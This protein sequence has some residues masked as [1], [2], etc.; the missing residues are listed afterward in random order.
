[1]ELK[2]KGRQVSSNCVVGE[3]KINRDYHRTTFR[4]TWDCLPFIDPTC[5][6]RFLL[7]CKHET[8]PLLLH[9]QTQTM[10]TLLPSTAAAA[11][12][13]AVWANPR[14]WGTPT[15][16]H[17]PKTPHL[18]ST[19]TLEL[20]HVQH[21]GV[22]GLQSS[23]TLWLCYAPTIFLLNLSG[24]VCWFLLVKIC[25]QPGL[26]SLPQRACDG[27]PVWFSR[28]AWHPFITHV[29]HTQWCPL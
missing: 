18:I 26:L 28:R 15:A 8:P 20:R 1:M 22:S 11:S 7:Y 5:L 3:A 10:S 16:S 13:S 19:H 2:K 25:G 14:H 4:R 23:N 6:L 27:S 9:L 29:H 12:L 17:M 24:P 21:I